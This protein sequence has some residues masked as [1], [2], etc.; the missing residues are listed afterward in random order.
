MHNY[1]ESETELKAIIEAKKW[2]NYYEGYEVLEGEEFSC[3]FLNSKIPNGYYECDIYE[4]VEECDRYSHEPIVSV[5][6]GDYNLIE[7][8]NEL[9]KEINT[10]YE[11][12]TEDFEYDKTGYLKN[13]ESIAGD[14]DRMQY[15]CK[16]EIEPWEKNLKVCYN[17]DRFVSQA[18]YEA[19][20]DSYPDEDDIQ[21]DY[22]THQDEL[23]EYAIKAQIEKHENPWKYYPEV[24]EALWK[25]EISNGYYDGLVEMEVKTILNEYNKAKKNG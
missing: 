24:L 3:K 14:Y 15:F 7:Y 16:E 4:S 5:E 25:N 10:R 17:G 21:W 12:E 23:F 13:I 18:E 22:A 20:L 9:N 11:L 8:F 1:S 19:Q 6:L 2:E